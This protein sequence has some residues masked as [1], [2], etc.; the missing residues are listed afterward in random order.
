MIIFE[1]SQK[2]EKRSQSRPPSGEHIYATVNK[3]ASG[4]PF[5]KSPALKDDD[6]SKHEARKFLHLYSP[7][8]LG[9]ETTRGT[10]SL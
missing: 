8:C 1:S 9:Q 2:Q 3:S 5:V 7:S 4:S 6:L 10:F